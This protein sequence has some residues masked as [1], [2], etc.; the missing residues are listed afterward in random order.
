MY[1]LYFIAKNNLKKKKS[2]AA[3]LTGLIILA[4]LL[5]YIGIS[6]LSN[7]GKVVNKTYELTNA[8][9]WYMLNSAAAV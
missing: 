7:M 1:S 2:D 5:L 4:A 3:V 6:T 8:A 9:D